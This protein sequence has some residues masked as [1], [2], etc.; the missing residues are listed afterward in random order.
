[1]LRSQTFSY[2][3][4]FG[5]TLDRINGSHYIYV[6]KKCKRIISIQPVGKDV[7]P[8]QI[9]QFIILVEQYNLKMEE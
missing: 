5:F 1:M 7:K 9:R 8:Y 6:H 2:L 3:E 4:A